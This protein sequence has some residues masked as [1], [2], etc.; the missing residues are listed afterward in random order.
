MTRRFTLKLILFTLP[1][2]LSFS[3]VIGLAIYSGEAMPLRWVINMQLHDPTIVYDPTTHEH[4]F[5][6]KAAMMHERQPE[7]VIVGS[8]RVA[9]YHSGLLNKNQQRFYNAGGLGWELRE[10]EAIVDQFNV[11][12]KPQVLVFAVDQWLFNADTAWERTQFPLLSTYIDLDATQVALATRRMLKNIALG[13]IHP[14]QTENPLNG[15][16][17]LGF[18]AITSGR[19][20]LADG[21]MQERSAPSEENA[22][23][24]RQRSVRQFEN[25]VTFCLPGAM[26]SMDALAQLDRILRKADALGIEVIGFA[27]PFIPEVYRQLTNDVR[28]TYYPQAVLDIETTFERHG[29]SFFDFGDVTVIGGI[30][31]E[32]LDF[33]HTSEGLTLKLWVYLVQSRPDLFDP[34][35]DLTT[36]AP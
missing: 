3:V 25:G 34:Y 20:Y 7:V 21:S 9:F 17:A 35:V 24:R 23:R 4:I 8:S 15:R 19:G 31:E 12:N 33:V 18:F 29:F 11:E 16:R 30:R 26:V 10:I 28:Y 36:L 13:K 1:L 6:Y 27:P 22:E 14:F 32:F 2:A 5:A